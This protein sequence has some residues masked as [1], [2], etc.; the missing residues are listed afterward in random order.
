MTHG[1]NPALHAFVNKVLSEHSDIPCLHIVYTN[2]HFPI[3]EMSTRY[4]RLM[5]HKAESI[6]WPFTEKLADL[7]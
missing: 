6:I 1:P 4:M 7:L 2:F 3:A 5:V